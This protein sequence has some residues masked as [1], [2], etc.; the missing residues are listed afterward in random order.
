M[1]KDAP[2]I[3]PEGHLSPEDERELRLYY[4]YDYTPT[5]TTKDHGYGNAYTA[6]RADRDYAWQTQKGSDQALTRSEELRVT[7]ER[8]PTGKKRARR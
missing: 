3:D 2:R 8:Q 1:I 6:Q 4:G 7:K 5:K